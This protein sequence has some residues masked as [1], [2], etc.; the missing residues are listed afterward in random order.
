[1]PMADY[2]R[3]R[4][5][6]RSR[7][8]AIKRDRR[9]EVGPFATFYFENFDTMRHQVH[10]MLYIERGGEEQLMGELEAYNP[11]IPNGRELI[12]TVMFEIDEPERRKRILARLGGVEHRARL[13]IGGE[14]VAGEAADDQDRTSEEGK[15]SSVHF[16]YFRLTAA[17]A[18]AFKTPGTQVTAGFDHPEYEHM[19]LMPER[20]RAALA[21]DLD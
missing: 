3:V 13:A 14:A 16:V 20:V 1:M 7:V 4:A 21:G 11:L 6:E 8:S 18:A 2:A 5:A 15:A 19:A 9:L 10:E 17:Q 12:A